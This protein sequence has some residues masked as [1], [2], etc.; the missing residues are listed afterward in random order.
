MRWF[1]LP[2]M[3][4][5][6]IPLVN[7]DEIFLK[8]G[9]T[10]VGDILTSHD[11]PTLNVKVQE[12]SISAVLH[13]DLRNVIEIRSGDTS[14]QAAIRE[15]TDARRKMSSSATADDI[16]K[17]ALSAQDVKARI[18][19]RELARDTIARDSNHLDAREALGYERR[20]S[21]WLLPHEAA[22]EDGKVFVDGRWI[23]REQFDFQE[24]RRL[25]K[26]DEERQRREDRLER[27][28]RLAAIPRSQPI[29]SGFSHSYVSG[30]HVPFWGSW[31]GWGG[32]WGGSSCKRTIVVPYSNKIDDGEDHKPTSTI[33][34]DGRFMIGG[35]TYGSGLWNSSANPRIYRAGYAGSYGGPTTVPHHGY[36][37]GGGSC[38]SGS[39]GRSYGYGGGWRFGFTRSTGSSRIGVVI[40]GR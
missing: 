1:H 36:G 14:R 34:S 16:W 37:W 26:I 2:L 3:L 29:S 17:L 20:G 38:S 10:I 39:Y 13:I 23:T 7:G 24:E 15:I 30:Y 6:A 25:Q 12:G 40:G 33:D 11:A 32:R 27:R 35:K 31:G 21:A 8:D 18:L 9:R 22:L 19:F 4:L 5:L 28:E